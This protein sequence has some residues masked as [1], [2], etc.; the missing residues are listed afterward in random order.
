[1]QAQLSDGANG[2][3]GQNEK[4]WRCT[5]LPD[6]ST[7]QPSC[8]KRS[9]PTAAKRLRADE[10]WFKRYDEVLWRKC[11]QLFCEGEKNIP[12]NKSLFSET[13]LVT[14]PLALDL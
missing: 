13:D 6:M 3:A 2:V 9:W 12:A 7:R 4:S 5:S 14:I 10:T 8:K 11:R 1:M